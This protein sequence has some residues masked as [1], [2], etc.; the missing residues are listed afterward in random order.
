[1]TEE[2]KNTHLKL[3]IPQE[4]K[5]QIRKHAYSKGLSMSS[6]I[7]YVLSEYMENYSVQEDKN[8]LKTG[9]NCDER[10]FK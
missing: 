5:E 4:K 6:Y 7:R 10:R 8:I 1:M 3:R 9:G 2:I